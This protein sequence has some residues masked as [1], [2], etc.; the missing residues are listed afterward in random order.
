MAKIILLGIL[1]GVLGILM[2]EDAFHKGL[3]GSPLFVPMVFWY[4]L[5]F[6]ALDWAV[7]K[8]KLRD[9]QLFL[10][11]AILGILIGGILDNE[12]L[13]PKGQLNIFLGVVP[14][15]A[16]VNMLTWGAVFVLIL[17][18]VN[19]VVPRGQKN[20]GVWAPAGFAFLTLIMMGPG[21]PGTLANA[22]PLGIL[23]L[24]TLASFLFIQLRKQVKKIQTMQEARP[25][26][27]KN[28]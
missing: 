20:A 7:V 14:D 9:R 3:I 24:L 19:W 5:L 21:L 2:G 17:Y 28:K 11:S 10:L 13:A 12:F 6:L 4:G 18:F 25:V 16:I 26:L 8:Y 23:T 22:N 27:K 1:G 15:S